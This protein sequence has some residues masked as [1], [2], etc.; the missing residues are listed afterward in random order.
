MLILPFRRRLHWGGFTVFPGSSGNFGPGTHNISIPDYHTFTIRLWAGGGGGGGVTADSYTVNQIAGG[1]GGTSSFFGV[2]AYGGT[3]GYNA[4]ASRFGAGQGSS[5]S[6]GGAS[7]G[8]V[9][10]T[11]G[12]AGGGAGAQFNP[13]AFLYIGGTGGAGGYAQKT[14]QRGAAGAPIPRQVITLVVGGGGAGG[15]GEYGY[16][17]NGGNGV[18]NYSWT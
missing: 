14:W 9:N 13:G 1:T 7:G 6:P 15:Y 18:A 4:S 5:G 10:S 12:G 3:G 11:G 16:G 17:A 2:A 8:D